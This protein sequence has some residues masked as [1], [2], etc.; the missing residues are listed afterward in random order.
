MPKHEDFHE[1]KGAFI[2]RVTDAAE[3]RGMPRDQAYQWAQQR[4]DKAMR[5]VVRR[6]EEEGSSR[7]IEVNTK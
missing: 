3:K 4:A 5:N 2:K 7:P 6:R 1:T